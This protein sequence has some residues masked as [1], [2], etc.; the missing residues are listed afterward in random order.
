[1]IVGGCSGKGREPVFLKV[2]H[3][4][5]DHTA[6]FFYDPKLVMIPDYTKSEWTKSVKSVVA[7]F[8]SKTSSALLKTFMLPIVPFWKV[9]RSV[10]LLDSDGQGQNAIDSAAHELVDDYILPSG[11]IR[12][13]TATRVVKQWETHGLKMTDIHYRQRCSGL[14]EEIAAH[15]II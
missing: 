3:T 10:S 6:I 13:S 9:I 8:A 14:L 7:S 4:K 2:G 5:A 12:T 11:I 15:N 1:M